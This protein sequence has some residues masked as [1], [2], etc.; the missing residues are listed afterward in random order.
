[1]PL[2]HDI[3]LKDLYTTAEK[4]QLGNIIKAPQAGTGCPLYFKI[5]SDNPD[6]PKEFAPINK[7]EF[8]KLQSEYLQKKAANNEAGMTQPLEE[9]GR[10][11]TRH[12]NRR[13]KRRHHKKRHT[14]RR[15]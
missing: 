11:R 9:G 7:N 1:M 4:A 5:T 10:R 2:V 14:K 3:L 13:T 15:H 8:N 6:K 12:K